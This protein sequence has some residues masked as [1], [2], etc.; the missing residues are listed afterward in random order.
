MNT[1]HTTPT[2]QH[3]PLPEEAAALQR[4]FEVQIESAALVASALVAA[5]EERA[6]AGQAP[7]TPETLSGTGSFTR[8]KRSLEN[9]FG[10]STT[11][12]SENK[13]S[14]TPKRVRSERGRGSC[15]GAA[16]SSSYR[17]NDPGS[18]G[19]PDNHGGPGG[20]GRSTSVS[21]Y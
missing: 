6:R 2:G 4:R 10:N 8:V 12:K 17:P 14:N 5:N 20:P 1:R 19:G 13:N 21:A 7:I 18:P 9:A 3:Q 11:N 15:S 16:L